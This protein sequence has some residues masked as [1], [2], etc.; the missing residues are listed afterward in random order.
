MKPSNIDTLQLAILLAVTVFAASGCKTKEEVEN[1]LLDEQ[2]GWE[3]VF[4]QQW[5]TNLTEVLSNASG[6]GWS[7]IEFVESPEVVL[8]DNVSPEDRET[9]ES[10]AEK[11]FAWVR[12]QTLSVRFPGTF[13]LSGNDS[14][15][16]GILLDT[17][18]DEKFRKQAW[19]SLR[20][21]SEKPVDFIFEIEANVTVAEKT[22]HGYRGG[23]IMTYILEE[24]YFVDRLA[25][26]QGGITFEPTGERSSVTYRR[27]H[28]FSPTFTLMQTEN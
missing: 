11:G 17:R 1:A 7:I 26:T 12:N 9:L 4:A 25:R 21:T 16:A 13:E 6:E 10:C 20:V 15:A 19:A 5:R 3:Q 23:S 8:A 22:E 28:L 24:S 18:L 27:Y 2:R 14:L